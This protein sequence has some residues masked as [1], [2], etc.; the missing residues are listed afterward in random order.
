MPKVK[1][2][3][4]VY[5]E[6]DEEGNEY[7]LAIEPLSGAQAQGDTV[8]E[9]MEKVKEEVV[10]MADAWCESELKEAVKAEIVEVEMPEA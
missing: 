10:K 9:A 3:V 2:G 7:Y 4:V 5:K 1:V 8:E 6:K